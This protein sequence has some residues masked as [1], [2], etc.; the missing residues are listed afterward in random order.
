M[1]QLTAEGVLINYN[2]GNIVLLSQN[3]IYHIKYKD[4]LFMQPTKVLK[5]ENYTK[6]FQDL[7]QLILK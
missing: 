5:L 4:I 2:S 1:F 6:E 7:L 3:G